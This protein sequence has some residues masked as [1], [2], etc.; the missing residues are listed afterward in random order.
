M[1]SAE[2]LGSSGWGSPHLDIGISDY[3]IEVSGPV[4]RHTMEIAWPETTES[5]LRFRSEDGAC[6]GEP[7]V[8]CN[9]AGCGITR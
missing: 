7:T 3:R 2:E 1:K 9:L 4:T 5:R 8:V 6:D